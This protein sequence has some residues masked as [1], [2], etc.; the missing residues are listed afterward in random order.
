LVSDA[1]AGKIRAASVFQT[2]FS[3]RDESAA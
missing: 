1:E 2:A 3:G